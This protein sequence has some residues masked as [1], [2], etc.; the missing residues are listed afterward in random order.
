MWDIQCLVVL[1]FYNSFLFCSTYFGL[2]CLQCNEQLGK[3]YV[4]SAPDID[5]LRGHFCL[6]AEKLNRLVKLDTEL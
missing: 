1:I 4:A 5:F 6:D 2:Y 3:K